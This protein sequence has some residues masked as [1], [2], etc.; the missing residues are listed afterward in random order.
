V[1]GLWRRALA[2]GPGIWASGDG[3]LRK[4]DARVTMRAMIDASSGKDFRRKIRSLPRERR[5]EL[6]RAVRAG[7]AVNDPRDAQLA[8]AWTQRMQRSKWPSWF[9]PATRPH[10]KRAFL[11]WMHAAWVVAVIVTA[12]I[13]AIWHRGEIIR[14]AAVA[15]LAYSILSTTWLF[16]LIL[17]TRW[18]AREAERRNREL[19]DP[20]DRSSRSRPTARQ[21]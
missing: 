13:G 7:R 12:L 1:L 4:E 15:V 2:C 6:G 3:V 10:G 21:A 17:R 8:V 14:W 18:N 16:R 11:W 19:L 9:L 20:P 5:R